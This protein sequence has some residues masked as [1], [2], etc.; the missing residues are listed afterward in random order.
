MYNVSRKYRK[1]NNSRLQ[2]E[3]G[4]SNKQLEYIETGGRM[5][6]RRPKQNKQ[7]DSSIYFQQ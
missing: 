1:D 4:T 2:V 6:G 5:P 3:G 7:A